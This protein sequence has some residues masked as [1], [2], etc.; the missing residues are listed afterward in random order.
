[1][2]SFRGGREGEGELLLQRAARESGPCERSDVC[3]SC[4][5]RGLRGSGSAE[6]THAAR[7]LKLC[8]SC[9]LGAGIAVGPERRGVQGKGR[10]ALE[11]VRQNPVGVSPHRPQQCENHDVAAKTGLSD[12][13]KNVFIVTTHNS[14]T[15]THTPGSF[16]NQCDSGAPVDFCLGGCV[17]ERQPAVSV[18]LVRGDRLLT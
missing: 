4:W 2:T 8:P 18:R 17:C 16:L 10:V 5:L 9:V 1:M 12:V 15:D 13:E 7:S 11:W 14:D 3:T 6:R